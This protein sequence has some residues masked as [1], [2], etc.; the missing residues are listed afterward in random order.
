MVLHHWILELVE[1][2]VEV[3]FKIGFKG[4]VVTLLLLGFDQVLI[5]TYLGFEEIQ[6]CEQT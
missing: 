6:V 4:R 5:G 2:E 1:F 3:K